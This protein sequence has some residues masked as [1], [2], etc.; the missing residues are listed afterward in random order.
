MGSPAATARPRDCALLEALR[1][2]DADGIDQRV[3]PAWN[4][5]TR[6]STL[7]RPDVDRW[8]RL[9]RPDRRARKTR[10]VW[11]VTHNRPRPAADRP[12]T[13]TPSSS[14]LGSPVMTHR[15]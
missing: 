13:S 15:R 2:S 5:L 9:S 7:R 6:S 11:I 4:S 12:A 10:T 14:A 3:Y 1:A 8:L